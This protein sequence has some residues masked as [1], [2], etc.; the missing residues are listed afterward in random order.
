[1]ALKTEVLFVLDQ[2]VFPVRCMGAV[3]LC[4]I[5]LGCRRM[6]RLLRELLFRVAIKAELPPLFHQG[7]GLGGVRPL[8]TGTAGILQER[9]MTGLPQEFLVGGR[10]G[11]MALPAV[12]IRQRVTGMGLDDFL[13]TGVVAFLAEFARLPDQLV[14][15]RRS[16]G[17]MT[18]ETVR[19]GR[20]MNHLP[21][22]L[23]LPMALKTERRPRGLEQAGLAGAVRVVAGG[24]LPLFQY[25]MDVRLPERLVL[26]GM[27][28]I[29]EF[30]L[31]F[32]Q[33]EDADN[34]MAFM[35]GFAIFFVFEGMM[36]HLLLI[37]LANLPVTFDA[38]LLDN[39][40]GSRS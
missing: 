36:N 3:A 33:N 8:M 24:A 26:L 22:E 9:R 7:K 23:F 31:A 27:A 37:F 4:A 11:R 14:R 40:P 30:R 2:Q 1:M 10:M 12:A 35:T 17:I 29:A 18:G 6:G 13:F 38:F 32:L 34:A 16:M 25:T 21:L 19:C 15:I 39:P 5:A 28:V 20:L